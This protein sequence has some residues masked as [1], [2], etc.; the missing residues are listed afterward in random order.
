MFIKTLIKT[1]YSRAF[2]KSFFLKVNNSKQINSRK[3]PF[4]L[5]L[6]T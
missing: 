2:V 3:Q 4:C 6:D 5:D 1:F